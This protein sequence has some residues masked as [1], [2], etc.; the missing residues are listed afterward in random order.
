[1]GMKKLMLCCLALFCVLCGMCQEAAGPL[2]DRQLRNLNA[3][4]R[5]YGY[6]RYFHPSKEAL[7]ADWNHIAV[8]G[9][10]KIL[11][12]ATDVELIAALNSIF[13]PIA[14]TVD[15]VNT[16]QIK[17]EYPFPEGDI[18]YWHHRGENTRNSKRSIYQSKVQKGSVGKVL[19]QYKID[20][21]KPYITELVKGISIVMPVGVSVAGNETKLEQHKMK[22]Y[23]I[24]NREVRLAGV[25]IAW[26]ILQHFYPYWDV[27]N[28]NWASALNDALTKTAV[29]SNADEYL[30]TLQL[31]ALH[32]KDGHG[33]VY[34]DNIKE[35]WGG[36][37]V[38]P[39][40]AEGKV[41]VRKCIDCDAI[42]VKPGDEITAI[43]GK[44]ALELLEERARSK[45]GSPQWQKR[46][47]I[48]YLL[49]SVSENDSMSLELRDEQGRPYIRTLPRFVLTGVKEPFR[50]EKIEEIEEGIY[51]V[52]IDRIKDKDFKKALPQ[53]KE[54][55]GIIF[56]L[57]RYPVG[58]M[59]PLNHLTK[60]TILCARWNI[61]IVY[62]PDQQYLTEYDTTGRWKI[63]P[64]K[65]YLG[66]KKIVFIISGSAISYAETY[67]GIVEHYKLG[68]I[69]GE[70]ATAGA[71]GN[72]NF[73]ELPGNFSIMYT[74]MKVL[75]HDRSQHHLIGITPTHPQAITVQG[76]RNGKD[77]LI[78]KALSII[79]K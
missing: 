35:E 62:Y 20:L 57:K 70:E 29:D 3:F 47:S 6:V 73:I 10:A 69:I 59:L 53:L 66:D 68:Y 42:G 76:I 14:P 64:K 9:A 43:D 51:Y 75:K 17:K 40:L 44:P 1:M 25:V 16:S 34:N 18:Q 45:S 23:D 31:L 2:S 41:V 11:S 52:S 22:D 72:V 74:G 30:E 38:W 79:N 58:G 49:M 71:N 24:I 5:I 55:K 48:S 13:K 37:A 7:S 4:T 8:T 65:P 15:V 54:A 21:G 61:P 56:E 78:E 32:L 26:N 67:M 77:E 27:V 19:A 33:F 12:S 60:E 50:F 39:A 46:Y 28:A 63:R 36:V